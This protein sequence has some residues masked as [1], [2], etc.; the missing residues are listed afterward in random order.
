MTQHNAISSQALKSQLGLQVFQASADPKI[1]DVGGEPAMDSRYSRV[2]TV[3]Y[4][5][6][7]TDYI[8]QYV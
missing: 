8:L 2:H 3:V 6:H 1:S 5:Y 4:G 7:K